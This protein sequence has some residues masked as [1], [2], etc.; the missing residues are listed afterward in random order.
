[1]PCRKRK[2]LSLRFRLRPSQAHFD[3]NVTL[4]IRLT[5]NGETVTDYASGI[6]THPAKWDQTSQKVTGRS[7]RSAEINERLAEVELQHREILRELKRRHANGIGPLP[8]AGL[9]KKEFLDPGSTNLTLDTCYDRFLNLLDSQVSEEDGFS[10]K[11]LDRYYHARKLMRLYLQATAEPKLKI[12]AVTTAWGRRFHSWLQTHS[13]VGKRQMKKDSAN[14]YLACVRKALDYAVEDGQIATNLLDKFRPKRGKGK[15]VYFLEPI[16]IDRLMGL[17]LTGSMSVTLW[18]AKLMCL[19]GM[20]YCD[21]VRY[22]R[23]PKSFHQSSLGGKT[24]IVIQRSKP[25]RNY[26]EIYLLPETEA[27][28]LEHPS[29]PDAPVLAD[30]NRNLKVI[31]NAIEFPMTFTSKICRKTAGA[32]FLRLGFQIASVSNMLGHSSIRTTETHYVRVTSGHIDYDIERVS[33]QTEVRSIRPIIN[34]E[35]FFRVA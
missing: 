25:P 30:I 32:H 2:E 14:K 18:W 12:A 4:Q 19:T 24:K 16:H 8:T 22:A 13:G 15:E 29:G 1:M 9:V 11:T 3:R 33:R 23:N 10:E 6:Q 27:L 31:Q 26:C 34:K 17:Q 5:V 35:P 28:F 7:G 20:D 21:A